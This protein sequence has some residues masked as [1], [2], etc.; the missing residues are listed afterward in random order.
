[1][2]GLLYYKSVL[3]ASTATLLDMNKDVK[4]AR[5]GNAAEQQDEVIGYPMEYKKISILDPTAGPTAFL[6]PVVLVPIV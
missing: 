3:I 6:V 2:S 1:M 5:N 4:I